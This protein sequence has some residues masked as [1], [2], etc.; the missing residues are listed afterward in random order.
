MS[1]N[2]EKGNSGSL[3]CTTH[4]ICV[5]IFRHS[6]P[7]S[8]SDANRKSEAKIIIVFFNPKSKCRGIIY[9]SVAFEWSSTQK[10]ENGL[11]RTIDSLNTL[12]PR[13][14]ISRLI[15]FRELYHSQS[16]FQAGTETSLIA[17]NAEMTTILKWSPVNHTAALFPRRF[18]L[19]HRMEFAASLHCSI[20]QELCLPSL[21]NIQQMTTLLCVISC[22]LH[23]V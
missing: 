21:K 6:S 13:H 7:P 12:Q 16:W 9:A 8:Y 23:I 22:V 2:F 3:N 11:D 18:W 5:D 14:Q 15:F 17:Y 4:V 1:R 10:T 19:R 20:K